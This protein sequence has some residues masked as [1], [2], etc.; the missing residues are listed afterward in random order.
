MRK[1][2]SLARACIDRYAM[3][4]PDDKIVVGVSGGKDSLTLLA[5]LAE[6]RRFYPHPFE[7]EAVSLAMGFEGMDFEPVAQLCRRLDV[8]YTVRE[9]N[10]KQVVFDIRQEKNPCS[11]CAKL[12]RG[13]L[14]RAAT[15]L[16]ANKVALGHHQD[17]AVETFM[18]SL[19][20][21]GGIRCFQ[22][23]TFLDR[24]GVTQIRPLLFVKERQIRNFAIRQALPVVHNPCPADKHTKRQEVK[25]LLLELEARYPTLRENIFGGLQTSELKGWKPERP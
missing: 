5:V 2:L 21:E 14:N 4:A 15:E 16:G 8:P 25:D 6:L 10:I 11:L 19:L 12:R 23:T 24:T 1:M 17:D 9:T 18:L 22:P 20:Y 13:A 7:L 3:I